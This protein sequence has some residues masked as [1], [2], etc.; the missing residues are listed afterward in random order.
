MLR[1]R[2]RVSTSDSGA[3]LEYLRHVGWPE[4]TIQFYRLHLR[5]MPLP[6]FKPVWD[7]PLVDEDG[8]AWLSR[9]TSP[10]PDATT[11]DVFDPSGALLGAVSV[12]S[13]ITLHQVTSTYVVGTM[14]DEL[15][16]AKAVVIAETLP[17]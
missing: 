1:T 5:E 4:E 16:R 2:D 13:N 11:W 12:P 8:R 6:E 14:R 17:G 7:Y 9:V 10:E 3:Y 15:D